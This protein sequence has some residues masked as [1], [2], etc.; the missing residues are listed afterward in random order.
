MLDFAV[1]DSSSPCLEARRRRSILDCI[2]SSM[3]DPID[4][5]L[6]AILEKC[7]P[8]ERI[9]LVCDRFL[10]LLTMSLNLACDSSLRLSLDKGNIISGQAGWF[11]PEFCR[12]C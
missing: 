6:R 5:E 11:S 10:I 1:H 12:L 2:I 3:V 7:V 4:Q 9:T 8:G